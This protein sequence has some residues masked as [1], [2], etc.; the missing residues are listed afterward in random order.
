MAGDR[1]RRWLSPVGVLTVAALLPFFAAAAVHEPAAAQDPAPTGAGPVFATSDQCIACRRAWIHLTARDQ[2]GRTIFESGAPQ[3][4][5]SIAGNANDHD[6]GAF[7]PHYTEI[8]AADQVQIY[9]P[10]IGDSGG[11]VTTALL[12]GVRY[13][14]DNRLLP[15]GFDKAAAASDVAVQ[16]AADADTDFTGGGDRVR[17][18]INA[19]DGV[20]SVSVTA[21]LLFQTIGY[22]WA[23]NLADY[24]AFETNRFVGYYEANADGSVMVLAES[25]AEG[26]R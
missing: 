7:E 26:R 1:P 14:K 18:R 2:A 19:G 12:R 23:R 8:T 6:A 11:N 22:R 13:L 25:S 21:R 16:G 9:E 10:I 5:G 24:D 17:Y 4:D 20:T 3:S 15:E